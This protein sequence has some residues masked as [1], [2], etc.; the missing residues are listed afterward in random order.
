MQL[1]GMCAGDRVLPGWPLEA[2]CGRL[3]R[4]RGPERVRPG[5]GLDKEHPEW[6]LQCKDSDDKLLNLALP[7]G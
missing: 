3:S 4:R 2:G 7:S 5:T 6:L 1:D